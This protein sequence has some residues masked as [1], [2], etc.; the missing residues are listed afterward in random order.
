MAKVIE[1][2][3]DRRDFLRL[4]GGLFVR[5]AGFLLQAA[6]NDQ[7]T[8]RVG[9]T[10]SKKLGN[11]VARNR[12][13]RRLR[14]IARQILPIH[15]REGWDYVFIGRHETTSLRDFT[16]LEADAKWALGKIHS[17]ARSE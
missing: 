10:C 2:L 9:F 7:G 12:A 16:R 13:K 17:E 11:A 15:G 8:I 1:I 5:P 6:P 14:E 4:R 3:K